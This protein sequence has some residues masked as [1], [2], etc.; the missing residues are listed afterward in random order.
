MQLENLL[1]P[2][3]QPSISL[4]LNFLQKM[5]T[6]DVWHL[7][8]VHLRGTVESKSFGL[9]K[10]GKVRAWLDAKQGE[11]NCYFYINRLKFG[12]T[13]LM[14]SKSDIKFAMFC[15]VA[16]DSCNPV[17]LARVQAFSPTPSLVFQNASGYQALWRLGAMTKNFDR[18]ERINRAL[19]NQ[20]GG[21]NG[22]HINS[23]M[24][25]PGTIALPRSAKLPADSIASVIEVVNDYR[26]IRELKSSP[27]FKLD[28]FPET[29]SPNLKPITFPKNEKVTPLGSKPN[30]ALDF[31]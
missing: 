1:A 5:F 19:K 30:Q 17:A 9:D 27:T 13:S 6:N 14:S 18:V 10:R 12:A 25:L 7:V 11:T 8:A 29:H 28:D 2:S 15:H 20:L 23:I 31:I 4:A 26:P 21:D 3:P 22:F 24:P 16:I